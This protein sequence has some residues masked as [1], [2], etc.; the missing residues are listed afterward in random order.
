MVSKN[1]NL[2]SQYEEVQKWKMYSRTL[3]V[4]NL[5]KLANENSLSESQTLVCKLFSEISKFRDINIY[6]RIIT[7]KFKSLQRRKKN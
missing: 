3:M 5:R 2:N 7:K 4:Y 1:M 6:F